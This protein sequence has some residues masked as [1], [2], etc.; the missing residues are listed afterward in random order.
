MLA[1]CAVV[2]VLD[3][4]VAEFS[5]R[6]MIKVFGLALDRPDVPFECWVVVMSCRYRLWKLQSDQICVT[7]K[8]L[9]RCKVNHELQKLNLQKIYI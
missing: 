3:I 8:H 1:S 4:Y 7:I 2:M 5:L 6:L 9:L